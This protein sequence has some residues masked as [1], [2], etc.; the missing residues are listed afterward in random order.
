MTAVLLREI[1]FEDFGVYRG[2]QTID[3]CPPV[4]DRP[5]VL[6]GGRNGAGKTTLLKGLNLV[7]Y[8]KRAVGVGRT[9]AD[10]E[11]Y[12]REAIYRGT[13][14][15]DGAALELHF[16]ATYDGVLA[17]FR[18]RRYW[19]VSSDGQ[20]LDHLAVFH[21]GDKSTFLTD[22]WDEV[23]E[24][25]LPLEISSLFFFDGE[26]I[27]ALA[28][29]EKASQVTKTAIESLLGLS[30]LD[31]LAVD[32]VALE[33]RKRAASVDDETSRDLAALGKEAESARTALEVAVQDQASC[34]NDID[35]A[36]GVLEAA[37]RDFRNAGGEAF[38]Q[39]SESESRREAARVRINELQEQ[40]LEAVAGSLPLRL[41]DSLL[42]R[43]I[44]QARLEQESAEARLLVGV[45][46]ERDRMVMEEISD[47]LSA[48][49][50]DGIGVALGE[51]REKRSALSNYP[52]FL[53][54]PEEFAHR[55]S[56]LRQG[57][58]EHLNGQASDLIGQLGEAE[59][60]LEEADRQLA[61]VPSVEAIATAIDRCESAV[62]GLA[63]AQGRHHVRSEAVEI[64]EKDLATIERGLERRYEAASEMV[65]EG[66]DAERV[67]RHA[68]RARITVAQ[69]RSV[70]LE[71]HLGRIEAAVFASLGDLL[72]KENLIGDLKIDPES[73]E[74][75]LFDRL[76]KPLPSS[77]L[78][79]GERQVLALSLL[80]GLT[81]V[82]GR[83]LP[84]VIDTPLG[85][86]DSSHRQLIV[87]RYFPN[88]GRQVLL[89]STDEEIDEGLLQVL[90]PSTGIS[91]R[92]QHNDD[93][94]WTLAVPGYFWEVESNVA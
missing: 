85:R 94:D 48:S 43:T 68:E 63:E 86:L 76:G 87:E 37:R 30:L 38:E 27:E 84:T 20:V 40:V 80:W 46:T 55:A 19:N 53:D 77:S 61:A 6:F 36:K 24:E 45:L 90:A 62:A 11:F 58:L 72:H 73:F 10:Y 91:Y 22:H 32:L 21:N 82:S 7:L 57:G 71:K 8:G 33:R 17:E 25:I 83:G 34:Q 93:G 89:L 3:L 2:R 29:P 4:P 74:L 12:L 54:T 92:L 47:H 44:D 75:K 56:F 16:D 70:L 35:R 66:E 60:E 39:R 15:K 1:V 49:V 18:V 65:I 5:I 67:I 52:C 14:E 64:A 13:A 79:A 78:S 41:V 23:I 50:A 69:Y 59:S 88:A 9:R 28:D 51:D 81:R 26:K 42:G 31:R